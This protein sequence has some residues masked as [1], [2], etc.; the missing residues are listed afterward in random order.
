MLIT[1]VPLMR[2]SGPNILTLLLGPKKKTYC[3]L[4]DYRREGKWNGMGCNTSFASTHCA[5]CHHHDLKTL[6]CWAGVC[7]SSEKS[8]FMAFIFFLPC[9]HFCHLINVTHYYAPS[10]FRRK[11]LFDFCTST[12]K[13]KSYYEKL[14]QIHIPFLVN[15]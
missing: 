14:L 4:V 13:N 3:R 5:Q 12:T 6:S 2:H 1:T 15:A 9:K 8:I 10:L 7:A 11:H